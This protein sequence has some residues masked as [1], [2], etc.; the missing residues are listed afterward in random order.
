[1]QF[2]FFSFQWTKECASYFCG[3]YICS[4][5]F[6]FLIETIYVLFS[7]SWLLLFQKILSFKSITWSRS[8]EY[9]R[10]FVFFFVCFCQNLFSMNHQKVNILGM[11][12]NQTLHFLVKLSLTRRFFFCIFL[13]PF[14]IFLICQ[15]RINTCE[16][17]SKQRICNVSFFMKKA[18][19][20]SIISCQ[21]D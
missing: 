20:C 19:N 5:L 3:K 10:N 6:L 13:L 7:L 18:S 8:V 12:I 15:V 14:F 17:G 9:Q 16:L 21:K 1:M 11:I 2:W 4:G